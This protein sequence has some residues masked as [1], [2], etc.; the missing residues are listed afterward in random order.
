MEN[1]TKNDLISVAKYA[2]KAAL[3]AQQMLDDKQ[4]KQTEDGRLHNTKLLLENYR[5]FV[6][7]IDNATYS[8]DRVQ[9]AEAIEWFRM[10]YDPGNISDQK[11]A[12]I[13]S[14]AIKTRII[15]EHVKTVIA[16]YEDYCNRVMNTEM[17]R[18]R[19]DVLFQRYI[20]EIPM[21][22]EELAE[23]WFV[24]IRTIQHTVKDGIKDISSLIFGIEG[25]K[26]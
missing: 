19:Y 23:K 8:V 4:R 9:E 18:R 5:K 7:F 3:L 10:M 17:M 25:I 12:S 24:D 11:V 22:N 13:K 2:A 15:I 1:F 20:S 21:T 16:V 26:T 14:S 6:G